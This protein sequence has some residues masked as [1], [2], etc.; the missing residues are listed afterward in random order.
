MEKRGSFVLFWQGKCGTLSYI[1]WSASLVK[2]H[3]LDDEFANTRLGV[4]SR[5]KVQT[6][7]HGGG[8]VDFF[9]MSSKG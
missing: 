5:H 1:C 2:R 6:V 4:V 7:E 8:S 3:L 9:L